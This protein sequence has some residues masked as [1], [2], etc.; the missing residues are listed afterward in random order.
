MLTTEPI[1]QIAL[2]ARLNE[3]IIGGLP[4]PQ[5]IGFE[6]RGVARTK[7]TDWPA[8]AIITLNSGTDFAAWAD[9]LNIP[10][11][12]PQIRTPA[13]L[14]P[15]LE[16]RA[17]TI[18]DGWHLLLKAADPVPEDMQAELDARGLAPT[19]VSPDRAED[20]AQE[21]ADRAVAAIRSLPPMHTPAV[22][23]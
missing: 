12:P 1:P 17:Y 2:W 14:D 18:V 19:F 9:K 22:T 5:G 20:T 11:D 6:G 8:L 10:V 16:S 13:G 3:H 15:F 23:A 4:V 7:Y 21:L